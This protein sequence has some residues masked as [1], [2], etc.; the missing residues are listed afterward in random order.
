MSPHNANV[1]QGGT[2]DNGTWQTNG[3]PVKW[4]NTMI[5]DGGQSGF[6]VANPEFRFHN[7]YDASPD[8]N[9]SNGD[10]A[11]WIWIGDPTLVSRQAFYA[12]MISDPSSAKTHVRRDRPTVCRTKTAGLGTRTIA[13]AQA[14]CN[15]W[16]GTFDGSAVTGRSSAS[17]D[18]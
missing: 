5:G 8:V 15:E 1:L 2:Q 14:I 9:F 6:D 4:E 3:N 7:F 10:I 17:D 12:P 16:T 13:E 11:K 18:G